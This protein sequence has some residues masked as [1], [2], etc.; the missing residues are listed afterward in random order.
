MR[1]ENHDN[2]KNFL[3][4]ANMTGHFRA[5]ASL[6]IPRGQD[7][8]FPNFSSNFDQF[9]SFFLKFCSFSPSFWLSGWATR[10]PGKALATL[11]GHFQVGLHNQQFPCYSYVRL[12]TALTPPPP[13]R[14]CWRSDYI[15][16]I[17]SKHMEI[18]T[19]YCAGTQKVFEGKTTLFLKKWLH[20]QV[21][22]Y[23]LMKACRPMLLFTLPLILC[24]GTI[25]C[26]GFYRLCLDQLLVLCNHF[27]SKYRP[28]C[29]KY[30]SDV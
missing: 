22:D 24:V 17:G 6:T 4:F 10:P 21:I 26:L 23:E 15:Y 13:L 20:K 14:I 9:L 28:L 27:P 8:H 12:H 30:G 3:N 11:L 16:S 7:F 29:Y 25:S 19:A 2:Q 1:K 5:V 18:H